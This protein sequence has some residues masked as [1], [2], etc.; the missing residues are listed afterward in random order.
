MP[1]SGIV[2][3]TASEERV[4]GDEMPCLQYGE[5]ED[6]F[7]VI[8]ELWSAYMSHKYGTRGSFIEI[9]AEDVALMMALFKIGRMATAV[10]SKDDNYIDAIG[11]IACAG[12]I[13]AKC[14]AELDRCVYEARRSAEA[15][16]VSG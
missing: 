1:Q 2:R 9:V 6:N 3:D 7:A 14:I 8:G 5:P 16:E 15:A 11:Y 13:N 4:F 10:E 12:E